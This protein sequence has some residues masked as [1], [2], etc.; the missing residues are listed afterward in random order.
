MPTVSTLQAERLAAKILEAT[1]TP[2]DIAAN[3]AHHLAL[4]D[5][6]GHASHGLSIL[7]SYL[8]A[9]AAGQLVA[10]ARP[11]LMSD[12]GMLLAFDGHQGYG[13]HGVKVATEH[14]IT[15]AR[16]KGLCILTVRNSYHLGRAGHYG[17]M[18]AHA[19]L[20]YLAFINVVGRPALV[21]PFGGATAR[22]STNPLCFAMPIAPD[23]A[24]FLLDYATSAIAANKV[25][26]MAA[27][28]LPV[29][30][31]MLIDSAGNP[32]QDA[33]DLT[34][35]P[36]GALLPFGEHKGYALGFMAELLAGVMSGGG[37]LA[38]EES[39]T[40]GLR[41]N[42]FAILFDPGKF[43]QTSWQRAEGSAFADY[44]TG[45]PPA[46]A[47]MRVM[48]PGEPEA[49]HQSASAEHFEMT[50]SA[51]DLFANCARA[52]HLSP[53]ACLWPR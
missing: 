5:R 39:R 51:W 9:A 50:R 35:T 29:P 33:N 26:L 18:A 22:L 6:S 13:Q 53:E 45:C 27:A 49:D 1:G 23:R 21:A 24:P 31:G 15:R 16:E 19:G 37:T 12:E 30:E 28:D 38:S 47:G 43:G 8:S 52:H 17:E 46:E 11:Q 36:P 2:A 41:N 10:H 7:P 42:V 40:G 20:G 3:V 48:V 25:R 32:T 34:G 14:A 4:A 44:V